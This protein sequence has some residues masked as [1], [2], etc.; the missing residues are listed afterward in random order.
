MSNPQ[1]PSHDQPHGEQPPHGQPQYGGGPGYGG[2]PG[3]GGRP[4]FGGQPGYGGQPPYGAQPYPP[5]PPKKKSKVWLWVLLG[6]LALVLVVCGGC[7]ALLNNASDDTT[8]SSDRAS[9]AAPV[10]SEVRDGK[11]A[12]VVTQVDPPVATVGDNEYTKQT[13]Q[14]EY[15][16]VHVDVT[17][18]GDEAQSYFGENQKLIDGAGKEYSNDTGA[19][20]AINPDLTSEI[21]PGNKKSVIIAFDV[22]T[23]TDPAALVLHD[24]MF[25]NGARVALK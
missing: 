21:N 3:Y 14:G 23:G 5:Q 1:D 18:I 22:P 15:I 19:E 20:L 11:F 8:N 4:G 13:A 2:Q 7:F 12:F 17:N 16:L 9:S 6:V 24:S 25:S 10:G